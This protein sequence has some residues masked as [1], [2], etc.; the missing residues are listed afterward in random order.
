MD[1][2]T[3]LRGVVEVLETQDAHMEVGGRDAS[4]TKTEAVPSAAKQ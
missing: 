4:G 1:L 2:G 3:P